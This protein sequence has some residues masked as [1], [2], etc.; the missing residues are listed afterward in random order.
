MKNTELS[1]TEQ[2][3]PEGE[4]PEPAGSTAGIDANMRQRNIAL[5]MGIACL[6][7]GGIELWSS[8]WSVTELTVL[9]LGT[10]FALLL[11]WKTG[12]DPQGFGKPI[13]GKK[14]TD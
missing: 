2:S 14:D 13:W 10:G 4:Q 1:N 3:E 9:L 7:S 11:Y 5:I 12:I 6:I 8:A